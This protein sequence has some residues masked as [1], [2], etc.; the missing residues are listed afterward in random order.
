[1]C[2]TCFPR[3]SLPADASLSSTGSSK[4]SSPASTVLSRRYDF[5]PPVSPCF[6]AFAWRYHGS[7]QLLSYLP[8][9]PNA[10]R[11]AWG[12]SPGIP[13]RVFFRGDDRI[14]QVLGEPN[15]PFAHVLRLRQ[16]CLHQTIKE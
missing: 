10:K 3:L 13:I 8:P 7:I 15:Y 14:S 6:V 2:S 4:A 5:L 16:D 11:R 12:W 1:M 9:P